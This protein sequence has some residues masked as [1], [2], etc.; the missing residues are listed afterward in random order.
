MKSFIYVIL[1][2]LLFTCFG[3]YI[4]KEIYDFTNTY[5]SKVEIIENHIENDDLDSAKESLTN[6][7]KSWHKDRSPW[8]KILNHDNFDTI[9]LY[10]NILE[11]S[12]N[13]ND[14]SKAYEYI[15]RIKTTL[16][17]ILESE[18]FDL[19]HIM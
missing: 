5:T 8:Y 1:W 15:I 14:K 16:D 4:N 3:F 9:C 2:T 12:I 6:F 7:S 17:N 13:V 11:K 10:L 18:K 19:N